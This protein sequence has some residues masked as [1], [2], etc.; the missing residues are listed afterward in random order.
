MT[1][2]VLLLASAL[3]A[4][5][6]GASAGGPAPVRYRATLEGSSLRVSIDLPA[7]V[8]WDRAR[9][10]MPR[11]IP[12]GYGQVAYDEFVSDVR[13]T[14]RGVEGRVAARREDGS[15]F[16]LQIPDGGSIGTISYVVDVARMERDTLSGGDSSRARPDFAFLLGYSVFAFVEGLEARPVA[17]SFSTGEGRGTWPVV[18]TLSAKDVLASGSVTARAADFYALADAQI[19]A[20]PAFSWRRLRADVPLYLA[21]YS[22]GDRSEDVMAPLAEEAFGALTAYFATKPF[23]R[24]TLVFQYVNPVSPRHAYGFSMEHLDTATFLFAAN[25]AL[26]ANSTAR[27]KTLWRYNVAHHVAH[28]WIP[29]R[30]YGEGYFPFQW[31][32][33]P[34]IDTVWFSEGFAQFAA[35]DALD[36]ITPAENGISYRDSV[37]ALRF[38]RPLDEVLPAFLKSMPLVDL[39]RLASQRYSEDFRVGRT[40]FARGGLM[41]DAMDRRIRERTRGARSMRD[42]FRHFVAWTAREKRAFRIDEIPAI[43]R[44]ATGVDTR[45]V[46]DAWLGPIR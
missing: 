26:H 46:F 2:A 39:S 29:K 13:A 36:A 18:S 43:V 30:S 31:E 8:A 41:A 32:V 3:A 21:V 12:M 42:A 27:E 10:I 24:F 34:M 15:R 7:D 17:L 6:T 1:A 40:A 35:A 44:E 4:A 28:A 9:M 38:R 16:L 19:V 45:D 37:V 14:A 33:A 25:A 23:E 20:G 11:A 22:E 5:Q